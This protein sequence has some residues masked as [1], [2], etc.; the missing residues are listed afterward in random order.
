MADWVFDAILACGI[1]L[2]AWRCLFSRTLFAGVVLF[3]A[4]GL[5]MAVGWTRLDAPDIALVEAAIG[6]GLTGALLLDALAHVRGEQSA[7]AARPSELPDGSGWYRAAIAVAASAS[8]GLVAMAVWFL[9]LPVDVAGQHALE[10]MGEHPVSNAATAVLLDFR[11]YDTFLEMAVLALAGLGVLQLAGQRA[12][13]TRPQPSVP[14]SELQNGLTALLVP[15]MLLVAV[16]L[17]WAGTA[18]SGGA[19][20]AGAVLAAAGILVFLSDMGPGCVVDTSRTRAVLVLGVCAFLAAGVV[21]LAAGGAFLEWGHGWAY[22]AILAV[23]GMLTVAIGGTLSVLYAASATR[24]VPRCDR[25]E[26]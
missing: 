3:I 21:S 24:R 16:Y 5:L 23:E 1:V 13:T 7:D 15:P 12:A 11:A 4:F 22:P 20:P 25:E 17:Y 10:R 8:A 14:V 6:A 9:P 26:R 2:M 19:F 18:K